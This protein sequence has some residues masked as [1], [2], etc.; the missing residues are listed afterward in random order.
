MR[1]VERVPAPSAAQ[2][3]AA[4]QIYGRTV[5]WRRSDRA[6]RVLSRRVHGF[7][8]EAT[9]LKAVAIN[10]LYRTN[11]YAIVRVAAHVQR[12]LG[13]PDLR[14]AGPELVERM[15]A[16]PM[17]DGTVRSLP[18]FASKFAH[19]FIAP[20]RFPILDRYAETALRRHLGR[21]AIKDPLRP[22]LAF[23]RNIE[24]FR[25]CLGFRVTLA[26]LDHYLFIAGQHL[27]W[28]D[29]REQAA[30]GMEMKA[31]FMRGGKDLQRLFPGA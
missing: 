15:A 9:L 27:E 19:F 1:D 24:C 16:C 28:S 7:S 29:K 2:L 5:E 21:E 10:S 22:Y 17:T 4:K 13:R 25:K 14:S 23:A 8:P 18:S 11:I 3:A 30:I 6:L 26:D 20:E 12:T 31:M